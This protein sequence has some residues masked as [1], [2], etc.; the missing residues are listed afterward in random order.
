MRSSPA[1][2]EGGGPR[3]VAGGGVR[4]GFGAIPSPMDSF[5]LNMTF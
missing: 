5:I 4:S 1:F 2:A 3:S